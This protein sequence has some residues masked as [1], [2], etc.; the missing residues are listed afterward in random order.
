MPGRTR[1]DVAAWLRDLGLERYAPAFLDAEISPRSC[2][3]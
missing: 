3:S 2:P 1:V